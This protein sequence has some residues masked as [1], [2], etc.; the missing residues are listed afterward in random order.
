MLGEPLVCFI[1]DEPSDILWKWD[2]KVEHLLLRFWGYFRE[3]RC[4]FRVYFAFH[5]CT[6]LFC[7]GTLVFGAREFQK[8]GRR[9]VQKIWGQ[10]RP[11]K[12][13][14]V[15]HFCILWWWWQ[16][17][18]FVDKI[19]TMFWAPGVRMSPNIWDYPKSSNQSCLASV[20]VNLSWKMYHPQVKRVRRIHV[21]G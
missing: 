10:N 12:P 7:V 6:D 2:G 14:W 16:W 11:Q 21:W 4:S 3:H 8:I 17:K 5:A 18:V 1:G 13:M 15:C 20:L 9:P 19:Y